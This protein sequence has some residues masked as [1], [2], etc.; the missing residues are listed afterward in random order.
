MVFHIPSFPILA[1]CCVFVI[2]YLAEGVLT[3]HPSVNVKTRD[4]Q[5]KLACLSE[6]S[7]D[8]TVKLTPPQPTYTFTFSTLYSSKQN[9]KILFLSYLSVFKFS[10]L[11]VH[12]L[13]GLQMQPLLSCVNM[14][15][16]QIC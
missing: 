16:N 9:M 2:Q 4:G 1:K 13:A 7:F 5:F 8:S 3:F 14:L 11:L 10:E 15:H 6:K 12:V